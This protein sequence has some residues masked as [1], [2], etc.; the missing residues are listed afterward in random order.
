MLDS[1]ICNIFLRHAIQSP[2]RQIHLFDYQENENQRVPRILTALKIEILNE[3]F[4]FMT[5]WNFGIWC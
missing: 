4:I 5:V 2:N 1:L 3:K